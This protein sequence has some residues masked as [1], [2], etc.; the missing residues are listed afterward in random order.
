[1]WKKQNW[2]LKLVIKK[3]RHFS[4][5]SHMGR[6]YF[7]LAEVSIYCFN[8]NLNLHIFILVLC[9]FGQ[10]ETFCINL[11]CILF[12]NKIKRTHFIAFFCRYNRKEVDYTYNLYRY[13][14][15]VIP[16][17]VIYIIFF[18]VN[19]HKVNYMIVSVN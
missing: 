5:L 3:I 10:T 19:V 14:L 11:L 13:C 15:H 17:R 9:I 8:D 2:N 1:M 6:T 12:P 7:I 18:G 16:K 4:C